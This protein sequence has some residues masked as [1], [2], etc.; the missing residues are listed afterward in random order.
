MK[1]KAQACQ[2]AQAGVGE[3]FG[4]GASQGFAFTLEVGGFFN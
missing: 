2:A 4:S 3:A 1:S